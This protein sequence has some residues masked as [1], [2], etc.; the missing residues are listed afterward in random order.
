MKPGFYDPKRVS[1][2]RPIK[3][4]IVADAALQWAKAHNI[5][6]AAKDDPRICLMAIDMQLTFAHPDFE[7]PVAGALDDCTRLCNFIYENLGAITEIAPTMDTHTA[8]QIFHQTF[9]VCADGSPIPIMTT[10]SVDDVK[11]GK[12][13][14]NP[15]VAH[16]VSGDYMFLQ[17]HA[18]HYVETLAAGGKFNLCIWPFHALL[19]G[20]C[21]SS[22]TKHEIKGGNPLSENYSVLKPECTT[23]VGWRSIGQRNAKFI[24]K[25]LN[26]DK[27]VIGGEAKSHCVAWSIQDLLSEIA[28]VDKRLARKVYL[29]EDCT[30][31]VIIPGV[32][33]F[34]P[35]A[36]AAF[37]EF[38]DAGM[39]I[40]KS[41]TPISDW[42]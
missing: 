8:M 2:V 28:S 13:R 30:S 27:I 32:V 3:Y 21:R 18:L 7:L 33:D 23:T 16:S 40:V 15:A 12:Y 9:W 17:K 20:I 11:S 4:S 38:A 39:H 41:T 37:K 34:T 42:K 29:L 14:V 36:N 26:F 5:Q 19:G 1:E 22:Q 35:Q 25:L 31:P 10:I 24:D 6:P